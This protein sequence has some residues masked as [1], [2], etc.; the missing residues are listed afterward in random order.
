MGG[1]VVLVQMDVDA[2]RA[3]SPEDVRAE[4][5]QHHAD[6]RLERMGPAIRHR[7][8]EPQARAADQ[9]QRQRMAEAPAGALEQ[10]RPHAP[11]ARGQARDGG[12]VIGLERV[13]HAHQESR[14]EDRLHA[15]AILTRIFIEWS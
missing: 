10:R 7:G 13:P 11:G 5:Q 8:T 2:L 15:K 9:E 3:H 12:E 4:H 6:P 1:P 14:Q